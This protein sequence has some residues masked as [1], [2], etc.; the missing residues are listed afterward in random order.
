MSQTCTQHIHARSTLR[1]NDDVDDD[2]R[3][4]N[5]VLCEW[6]KKLRHRRIVACVDFLSVCVYKYVC[7]Q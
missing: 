7:R 1:A 5:I 4:H 2:K 3:Q 6:H